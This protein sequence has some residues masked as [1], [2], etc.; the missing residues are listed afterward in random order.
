[1]IDLNDL[2]KKITSNTAAILAV[3]LYGHPCNM[4]EINT[5]AKKNNLFVI[6]DC[7]QAHG[8]LYKN[9]KIG[10]LGTISVFSFYPGKNLGAFGDGGGIITNNDEL[11][12]RMLLIKN[13]S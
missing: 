2:K 4:D 6:K 5:I 10:N 8:A 7:A 3:H 9:K 1:M 13:F 12:D 11:Y